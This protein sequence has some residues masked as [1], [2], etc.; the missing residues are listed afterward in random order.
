MA[1][2]VVNNVSDK[3]D[4]SAT[5]GLIV[6]NACKVN[7]DKSISGVEALQ[8]KGLKVSS[9]IDALIVLRDSTNEYNSSSSPTKDD[10]FIN[11]V[12][13]G[14]D[15]EMVLKDLEPVVKL[16]PNGNYIMMAL[17]YMAKRKKK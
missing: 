10:E 11:N 8:R 12:T 9:I 3:I 14:I 17:K 4:L 6:S 7:Y 2:D 16:I 5:K 1:G 13:A 15:A